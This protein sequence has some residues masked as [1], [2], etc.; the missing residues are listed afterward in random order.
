MEACLP[1][2]VSDRSLSLWVVCECHLDTS[3]LGGLL[4]K[5]SGKGNV[6]LACPLSS[7]VQDLD[8]PMISSGC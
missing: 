8:F 1:S 2:I 4:G 7:R 5:R 3:S 6:F